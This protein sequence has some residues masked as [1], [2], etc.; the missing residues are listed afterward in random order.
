MAWIGET[1]M[2]SDLTPVRC[3]AAADGA[4]GWTTTLPGLAGRVLTQNQAVTALTLAER[5]A[6]GYGEDDPFVRGWRE[7]LGIPA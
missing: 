3:D 5:Y 1:A 2:T 7:E 4:G 6:A